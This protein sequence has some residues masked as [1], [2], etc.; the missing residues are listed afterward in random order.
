ME[1]KGYC[2]NLNKFLSKEHSEI[3]LME[4]FKKEGWFIESGFAICLDD[5][6]TVAS[7]M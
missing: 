5:V 4:K 2:D 6:I 7:D 1:N 3:E